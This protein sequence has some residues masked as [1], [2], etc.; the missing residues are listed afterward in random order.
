MRAV[1]AELADTPRREGETAFPERGKLIAKLHE[2][3][4]V[5]RRERRIKLQREVCEAWFWRWVDE[6]IE[7]T[8][9]Q[10]QEV[11]DSVKASGFTGRK[12]RIAI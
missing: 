10:E 5:R 8:G 4:D 6:Q 12:A 2:I 9:K 1:C 3:A 11:L 7:D